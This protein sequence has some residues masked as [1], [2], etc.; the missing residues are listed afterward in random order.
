MSRTL[1][2]TSSL[3]HESDSLGQR[4]ASL[5]APLFSGNGALQRLTVVQNILRQWP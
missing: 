3:S 2:Q 5:R 1:R 4:A